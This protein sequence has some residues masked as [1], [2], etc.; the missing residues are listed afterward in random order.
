MP[1]T[2]RIDTNALPPGIRDA[3]ASL[4]R[5][6]WEHGVIDGQLREM[7]RMRSA[8]TADCKL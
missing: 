6:L 8:V 4:V 1:T 2:A 7:I 3:Y 5:A